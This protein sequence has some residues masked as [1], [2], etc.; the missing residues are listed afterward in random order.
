MM[1][2]LEGKR[3]LHSFEAEILDDAAMDAALE[4]A[5]LKRVAFLDE[6]RAWVQAGPR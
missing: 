4:K 3:W 1:Y 5:G 6:L 2:E